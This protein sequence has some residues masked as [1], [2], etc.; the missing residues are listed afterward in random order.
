M[1]DSSYSQAPFCHKC[2]TEIYH[3]LFWVFD[4]WMD[5]FNEMG[6]DWGEVWLKMYERR[7]TEI[8]LMVSGKK[9]LFK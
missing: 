2:D 3:C 1:V 5:R 4:R 8:E 6:Q 9:A 7:N